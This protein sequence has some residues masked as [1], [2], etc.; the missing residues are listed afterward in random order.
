MAKSYNDVNNVLNAHHLGAPEVPDGALSVAQAGVEGGLGAGCVLPA[1][2]QRLQLQ[3]HLQQLQG[4]N[5]I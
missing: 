4:N 5:Y 2:L 3:Q 1:V